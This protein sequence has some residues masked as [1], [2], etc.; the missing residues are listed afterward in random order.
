MGHMGRRPR[1]V[2]REDSDAT[3]QSYGTAWSGSW[4]RSIYPA[5]QRRYACCFGAHCPRSHPSLHQ[6]RA[7]S[8]AVPSERARSPKH[9]VDAGVKHAATR[10]GVETVTQAAL[11]RRP[12]RGNVLNPA[13]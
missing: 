4:S 5:W 13:P 6:R 1:G 7:R 10:G 2:H 8:A 12:I 3:A 11:M 9:H